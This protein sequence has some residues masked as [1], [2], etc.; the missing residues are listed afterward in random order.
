MPQLP[1]GNVCSSDQTLLRDGA[2]VQPFWTRYPSLNERS[3]VHA[4]EQAMSTL[5]AG[6]QWLSPIPKMV[7]HGLM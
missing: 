2:L 6:T 1:C 7:R 5:R 4:A 3:K